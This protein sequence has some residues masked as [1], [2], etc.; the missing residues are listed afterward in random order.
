MAQKQAYSGQQNT[1]MCCGGIFDAKHFENH[2]M[3]MNTCTL[4]GWLFF[5]IRDFIKFFNAVLADTLPYLLSF[6]YSLVQYLLFIG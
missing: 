5:G 1:Y 6:Y 4:A 2:N 3:L